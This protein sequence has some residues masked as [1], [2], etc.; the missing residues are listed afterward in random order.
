MKKN[1][2]KMTCIIAAAGLMAGM[3]YNVPFSHAAHFTSSSYSWSS[4]GELKYKWLIENDN[5]E[6]I[7][8]IQ[9]LGED[10]NGQMTV[11]DNLSN[12]ADSWQLSGSKSYLYKSI[13]IQ[14]YANEDNGKKIVCSTDFK[15]N[16]YKSYNLS[17]G[18]VGV[19]SPTV[20]QIKSKWKSLKIKDKK[21]AF[22]KKPKNKKP[23]KQKG[24]VSK[25]TLKN[26]IK[27]LNFFRYVAGIPSNV[28][29]KASYQD[30]AQAAAY[31]NYND[32]S[33][34]ISHFPKKPKGMKS[35]MYKNGYKGAS[36]SN[37]AAGNYSI[38]DAICS[39]MSDSDSSN[40]DRIGH[41]RWCLNPTMKY[42]GFGIDSDIY[43]MYS[44][45]QSGKAECYGVHWP[46]DNTPVN[47]FSAYDAW[48]ISM[49]LPVEARGLK[50]KL[51]R[52][53]DNK[54][55]EF[56]SSLKNVNGNYLNVDNDGYGQT[57]CIIFRPKSIDEYKAGDTF[58]VDITCSEFTLSYNVNFFSL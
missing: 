28:K 5:S 19:K 52:L 43:A 29:I 13:N 16:L 24:K 27:T 20:A 1:T 36:S 31:L 8:G 44:F 22:S 33:A 11:L 30:L 41:R 23:Y 56:D 35:A 21:D 17:K 26:G 25:A 57:G 51:T 7:D 40:I 55:W 10:E 45:D 37:L 18:I 4:S 2:K 38:K 50:V 46:A 34:W 42:T 14:A 53:N 32:K 9:V 6:R 15:N 58:K 12:D 47:M 39:W 3:M 54:V 49:G 48:N